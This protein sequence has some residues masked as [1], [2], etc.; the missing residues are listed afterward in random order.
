MRLTTTDTIDKVALDT[1]LE[2]RPPSERDE[3]SMPGAEAG[4]A[5]GNHTVLTTIGEPQ[6]WYVREP[7]PEVGNN[8]TPLGAIDNDSRF[9]L[10]RFACSLRVESDVKVEFA[11]FEVK[12]WSPKDSGAQA[13]AFD[14]HPLEILEEHKGKQTIKLSPSL[15]FSK[16]VEVSVGEAG[17]EIEYSHLVPN[18]TASGLQES[19]FRW[20]LR[21]TPKHILQGTH[22]F[23]AVVKVPRGLDKLIVD[24][25]L[26]ARVSTS[27]GA[28]LLGR[29]PRP[30]VGRLRRELHIPT[31]TDDSHLAELIAGLK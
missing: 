4:N 11:R 17:V 22:W 7:K 15:K 25:D 6:W 12:L 30:A 31:P 3:R 29:L 1:Q 14:L 10:G 2:L 26:L 9:I 23:H 21:G 27:W 24:C 5:D 18:I 16:D 20:D 28:K 19:Q 8:I 13:I